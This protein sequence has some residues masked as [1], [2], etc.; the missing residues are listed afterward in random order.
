M[1]LL[2]I[3][4]GGS[5]IKGAPVC[6]ESGKLETERF[7]IATPKPAT[8][9]K[10]IKTA[11]EIVRHFDL[12]GPVGFGFPAV[13]KNG[14]VMTAA[15]IDSSWIGVNAAER[16]A[17]ATGRP[18]VLVNDADA[19]GMAEMRY[20]SGRGRDGVVVIATL[21]TGIGTSLFVDGKLVPSTEFGHIEMKGHVAEKYAA[22]S[23]RK[24]KRLGWRAWG[25]RVND[26]LCKL[27][28]LIRPDLIIVGGGASNKYEKF[29]P[30]FTVDTEVVPA[31]LRNQA[32]II[33][34]ALAAQ[35]AA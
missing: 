18:V 17:E 16:M 1:R 35:T 7:R 19:A 23:V 14:T 20:G 6:L 25:R 10:V 31:R 21:G 33:G 11:A 5:G 12:E 30:C 24:E 26:Y 2:G 22:D 4:I 8:P 29:F 15:N 28:E 34:A 3:D 32:G 13:I 9:D 27:N